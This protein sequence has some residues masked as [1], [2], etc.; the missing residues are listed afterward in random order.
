M[1]KEKRFKVGDTVLWVEKSRRYNFETRNSE[2]YIE[3][4]ELV[5]SGVGSK[6][7]TVASNNSWQRD[8]K[9]DIVTGIGDPRTRGTIYK[10]E[11]DYQQKEAEALKKALLNKEWERTITEIR[12]WNYRRPDSVSR[13]KLAQ[14]RA[15]LE[16]TP[17]E[18]SGKLW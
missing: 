17:I 8:Q 11:A 16:L 5:L 14:I 18:E 10:D 9:F 3:K 15:L 12:G 7:A 6:Y 2:D 13:E 4:K 1:K